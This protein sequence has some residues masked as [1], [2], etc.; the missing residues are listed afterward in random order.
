ML[1]INEAFNTLKKLY[2]M[3]SPDEEEKDTCDNHGCHNK[4]SISSSRKKIYSTHGENVQKTSTILSHLNVIYARVAVRMISKKKVKIAVSV[5]K[6]L[7]KKFMGLPI[8]RKY[9]VPNSAVVLEMQHLNEEKQ[10]IYNQVNNS[11]NEQFQTIY[12]QARAM[13]NKKRS[14]GK[15]SGGSETPSSPLNDRGNGENPSTNENDNHSNSPPPND[16]S[17]TNSDKDFQQIA[18]APLPTAKKKLDSLTSSEEIASFAKELEK[19]LKKKEQEIKTTPTDNN[20]SKT[21]LI[22]GVI[23]G[24]VFLL[25]EELRIKGGHYVKNRLL[26]KFRCLPL[27][28]KR[29]RQKEI[30]TLVELDSNGIGRYWEHM[31]NHIYHSAL[32]I[33]LLLKINYL[34][35]KNGTGKSTIFYLL[36]GVLVP[37]S[38]QEGSTGQK[39]L[40]NI[41]SILEQ[42]KPA[43]LWLFDEADNALD[44]NNQQQFQEKIKELSK[45]KMAELENRLAGQYHGGS[46]RK[47]ALEYRINKIDE[48]ITIYQTTLSPLDLSAAEQILNQQIGWEEQKSKILHIG[49]PGVGKTTWARMLAQ[50]C[51]REFFLVALGGLSDTSVLVGTSESSSGTE[52]GQL[53]RALIETKS[54]HPLILLDEIDKTGSSFK[55]AIQDCLVNVLDPTQNKEILDYYLEV[56]LDF[57]QTTFVITANDLKKIPNYLRSRMLIIELPGYNNEQKK[58]IAQ[59]IIKTRFTQNGGLGQDKLEITP[60][61]LT[62]LI[63]KT[64]EKGVRQL[65][66]GLNSLFEYCEGKWIKEIGRGET[67]SQI[68]ITP[69][70]VNQIIPH[71]FPNIDEEDGPTRH[72]EQKNYHEQLETL[73]KELKLLQGEKDNKQ[74]GLKLAKLHALPSWEEIE[75]IEK[76]ILLLAESKPS[77]PKETK[78]LPSNK[79]VELEE[80]LRNLQ[81]LSDWEIQK[82]KTAIQ[83]L[84]KEK[85][86]SPWNIK[87][88][89]WFILFAASLLIGGVYSLKNRH[90]GSIRNNPNIQYL[91]SEEE[92]Q[93]KINQLKTAKN[94]DDQQATI[95]FLTSYVPEIKCEAIHDELG[96]QLAITNHQKYESQK[97]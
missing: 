93:Q 74:S 15:E 70:L 19:E 66:K 44:E 88:N 79:L 64:R 95:E 81:Q 38:G 53:A 17:I 97:T 11:P 85:S 4:F 33:I 68:T 27:E 87:N 26:D 23:V 12:D 29:A 89:P 31:P 48:L 55:N 69:N 3:E 39:Q 9:F 58:E 21:G 67:E 49:P 37:Q 13:I 35:G 34:R 84:L 65:E 20:T 91:P 45:H 16:P 6:K 59:K 22:I 57:S 47:E 14:E 60:E 94:L 25:E 43:S 42:K 73:R 18:N 96:K 76:E 56:K 5:S 30:S 36:L 63:N 72:P 51:Q 75:I 77:P 7:V 83:D 92:A 10:E 24:G 28:E 61:A 82:L 1:E 40:A 78:K 80:K 2:G 62:T 41:N 46:Q 54:P 50:A 86:K 32:T 90:S 8:G 71:P 52:I